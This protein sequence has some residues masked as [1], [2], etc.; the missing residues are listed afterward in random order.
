M[1]KYV[2]LMMTVAA[3][4]A[5][6]NKEKEMLV[7]S[8]AQVISYSGDTT[9]ISLPSGEEFTLEVGDS[10]RVIP[11]ENGKGVRAMLVGTSFVKVMTSTNSALVPVTVQPRITKFVDPLLFFGE[12]MQAVKD[13]LGKP[14]S[15]SDNRLY[16][17]MNESGSCY[18][19]YNFKSGALYRIYAYP[20]DDTDAQNLYAY[21]NERYFVEIVDAHSYNYYDHFDLSRATLRVHFGHD[22]IGWF[23]E[24]ASYDP[25]NPYGF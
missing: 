13:S 23:A 12:S 14:L 7:V 10:C 2:F 9:Y 16:Y 17:K 8:P 4:L 25:A 22:G 3:L 19:A 18:Y 11:L 6:G 5:C 1:K 15:I 20:K 21:L 24:Y